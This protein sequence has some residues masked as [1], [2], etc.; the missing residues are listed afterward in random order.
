MCVHMCADMIADI[1]PGMCADMV[2]DICAGMCADE[3]ADAS[4][5]T[6]AGMYVNMCVAIVSIS[7]CA[8]SLT[9]FKKHTYTDQRFPGPG[10]YASKSQVCKSS[11]MGL[12]HQHDFNNVACATAFPSHVS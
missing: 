5:D 4:A 1:C 2:A 7:H 8:T 6:C 3:H 10:Q 9:L 12:E 11:G